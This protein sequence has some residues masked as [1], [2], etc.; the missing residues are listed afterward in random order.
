MPG[1]RTAIGEVWCDAPATLKPYL[2]PGGLP[3]VFNFELVLARWQAAA[4][5]AAIDGVLALASGSRAPWVIGNHDVPAPPAGTGWT[6][7]TPPPG[8]RPS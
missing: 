3:Q 6:T 1:A 8:R 2:A 7:G 5:R 4:F